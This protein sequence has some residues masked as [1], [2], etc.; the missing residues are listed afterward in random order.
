MAA[1]LRVE[2]LGMPMSTAS[3]FLFS[4]HHKDNFP[5]GNEQMGPDA[6]LLKSRR[7]GSDFGHPSGWSMYHGTDVP[8]FPKHP[9]R[10]FETITIV[11]RGFVDHTDSLGNSGR[12]GDG[13]VQWMTAGS[14]IS[15]CEMMP[16]LDRSNPNPLE[17]FQVWFNLPRASK[18]APATFKM[19]WGEDMPALTVDGAVVRVVAGSLPGVVPP[20][21]PPPDSYAFDA[22]HRVLI[23][24][25]ELA[26]GATWT[27]PACD[28]EVERSVYFFDGDTMKI[29]SREL[30]NH[31]RVVLDA[32]VPCVLT[33]TGSGAGVLVLQGRAIDEP[34]VSR[35]PFVGN[36]Q[37]DIVS[38]YADYER[39]GFGDW[40]WPGPAVVHKRNAPRFAYFS[41]GRREER[42]RRDTGP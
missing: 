41:D 17:L 2:A 33:A 18:G 20:P 22:E 3:P 13:D 10:G 1:V 27:L 34:V 25:V 16:L 36:T 19:L 9:H 29:D 12:F 37:Q 11:R 6:S 15:H 14:G 23:A 42:P 5:A 40:P 30:T 21:A 24:T 7:L 8:G 38:A 4:V 31:A 32:T 28:V 26:K 39:T 35:G